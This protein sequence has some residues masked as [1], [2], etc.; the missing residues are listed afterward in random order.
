MRVRDSQR[1][2]VYAAERVVFS[3]AENHEEYL[4]GEQEILKYHNK[5]LRSAWWKHRFPHLNE[6]SIRVVFW[7]GYRCFA[8]DNRRIK[9]SRVSTGKRSVLHE[10]AHLIARGDRHNDQFVMYYLELVK[11]YLGKGTWQTLKKSFQDKKVKIGRKSKKENKV[12]WEKMTSTVY[13]PQCDKS[14][15]IAITKTVSRCTCGYVMR[16][17]NGKLVKTRR[18]KVD[19][20]KYPDFV[21]N[22][23]CPHCNKKYKMSGYIGT[24]NCDCGKY[25]FIG[26]EYVVV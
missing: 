9:Y 17:K 5:V 7:N 1:S 19:V 15:L 23:I 14:W 20:S 12:H 3:N 13:C 26:Y 8:W 6:D 16:L 21:K 11:H 18:K 2:K 25:S 22:K 10:L 4:K 24:T